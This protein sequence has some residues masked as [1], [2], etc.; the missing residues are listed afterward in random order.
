MRTARDKFRRNFHVFLLCDHLSDYRFIVPCLLTT[1]FTALKQSVVA[2]RV[3]QPLFIKARLLKAVINIRRDN[4]IVLV[5]HKTKQFF[6]DRLR[7]VRI[8]V[9]E[10]IPTPICPVFLRCCIRIKSAR[11]HIVKA[12]F[13]LK[14]S[15]IFMKPLAVVGKSRRG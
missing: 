7:R 3:K 2:L 9:D 1:R 12:V 14:I 11:I 8:A 4:K 15:K 10:D 5:L 6:I 13:R